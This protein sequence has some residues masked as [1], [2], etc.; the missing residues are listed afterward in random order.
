M[1]GGFGS[2]VPVTLPPDPPALVCIF[3]DWFYRQHP[4]LQFHPR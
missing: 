3:N 4:E 2:L 1:T